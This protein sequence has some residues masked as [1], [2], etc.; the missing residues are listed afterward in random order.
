MMGAVRYITSDPI[1]LLGGSNVFGYSYQNTLTYIDPDGRSATN[2]WNQ[3]QKDNPGPV[4]ETREKYWKSLPPF[5]VDPKDPS[6]KPDA[7]PKSNPRRNSPFEL[8]PQALC[9]MSQRGA[10]RSIVEAF[11]TIDEFKNNM[12]PCT[13][14]CWQ[15]VR[16][17]RHYG[18]FECAVG[19]FSV[20]IFSC[21]RGPAYAYPQGSSIN[22]YRE[23]EMKKGMS[24]GC[25]ATY[26]DAEG[27]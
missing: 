23:G 13:K 6:S 14:A 10:K 11:K 22:V 24:N 5:N 9:K 2:P 19:K 21:S 12:Q 16:S 25:C 3:F 27:I 4:S 1:G 18:Y 7:M 26:R 20:S 15:I 17:S 8:L